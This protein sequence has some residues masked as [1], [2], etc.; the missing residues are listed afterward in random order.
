MDI[1]DIILEG[2]NWDYTMI[3]RIIMMGPLANKEDLMQINSI[4]TI[5]IDTISPYGWKTFKGNR[6]CAIL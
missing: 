6:S 2:I 3:K 5:D 4:F 1:L